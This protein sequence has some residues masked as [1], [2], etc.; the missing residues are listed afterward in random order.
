MYYFASFSCLKEE[1]ENNF[2]PKALL[3]KPPLHTPFLVLLL[4]CLG[5]DAI[6][7]ITVTLVFL[8]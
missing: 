2:W 4:S 3:L 6:D 8:F 5:K 1:G 7:G